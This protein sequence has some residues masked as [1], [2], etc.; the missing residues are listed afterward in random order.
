MLF[1]LTSDVQS[2]G[3]IRAYGLAPHLRAEHGRLTRQLDRSGARQAL[4]VLAVQALGWLLYSAGLMAAIA[5]VVLR[6]THG[7]LSLGTVLMSVSLIRRSRN[8]LSTAAAGSG[9]LVSTLATVDRLFWLQDHAAAAAER[10]GTLPA[11]ER[12]STGI[13]LRSV[14][15]G[16]PGRADPALRDFSAELPAG[17]TVAVVGENGSGK[18][19][20][21]KLLLGLYP[22]DAGEI[23]VDRT[24]LRDLDPDAWRSRCTAAF[25]DFSRLHLPAVQTVGVAELP[26]LDDEEAA[27]RALERAGGGDLPGKLPQGL[28]TLLG[29]AYTGGHGLS[30]GQWQKLALGR[31]MRRPD[32]LLV[33]LDEPTA[34][35]DA[36]A[37]FTLFQRY[38]EAARSAAGRTGA[39]T[40]LVSHRFATARS[41]DLIL[42]VEDGRAAEIGSHEELVAAGGKYAELFELQASAYR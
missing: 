10:A 8:Q 15:F 31:A 34:S 16:Y 4:R 26:G 11:P 12:L 39:V 19:T 7:A 36:R 37:E 29:S 24:P 13:S 42:F 6:A 14:S 28:S 21:V 3:E 38:A 17:A 40:V 22:P 35:L 27:L 41:A 5:F 32:P 20:L 9:Q 23:V 33:V 30:G 25:Q 1:G 2:A 18:T